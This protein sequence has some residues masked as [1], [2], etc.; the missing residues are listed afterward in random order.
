M[1]SQSLISTFEKLLNWGIKACFHRYKMDSAH[2]L[3]IKHGI[4]S[5]CQTLDM[6]AIKFFWKGKHYLLPAFSQLNLETARIATH[7]RTKNLYYHANTRSEHMGNSLFKRVVPLWNLLP[8][9]MKSGNQ[10]YGTLK[11][12]LRSS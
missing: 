11:K 10:T 4:I 5:V 8:D 12:R 2:D 6:N 1:V 7:E 3:R 9:K